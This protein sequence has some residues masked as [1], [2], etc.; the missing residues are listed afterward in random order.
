VKEAFQAS[1][2]VDIAGISYRQLDYWA[3]TDLVRP[4]VQDTMGS[5][6]FRFYSFEDLCELV[7][8]RALLDAG[9][10]LQFVRRVKGRKYPLLPPSDRQLRCG[11][12]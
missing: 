1:E 4:S 6:T 12:L 9:M 5:G 8:V 2:V 3:R 11:A 7:M 10:S